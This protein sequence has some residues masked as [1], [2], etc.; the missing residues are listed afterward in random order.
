[1]KNTEHADL[2]LALAR[3]APNGARALA[4]EAGVDD[5]RFQRVLA[6]RLHMPQDV[7]EALAKQLAFDVRGFKNCVVMSSICRQIE[8]LERLETLGFKWSLV[9][10]IATTRELM[11]GSPLQRYFICKLGF[12]TTLRVLVVRM[13]SI[14]FKQ[15][16]DKYRL[17]DLP[18]VEIDG[19]DLGLLNDISIE[20]VSSAEKGHLTKVLKTAV[21]DGV[22]DGVMELVH[23]CMEEG[24]VTPSAKPMRRT[25][26]LPNSARIADTSSRLQE[27]DEPTRN[28]SAT[29][30]MYPI[31]AVFKGADAIGVRGD[32]TPVF[33]DI[34]TL[35]HGR[36]CRVSPHARQYCQQ[37]IV[38]EQ[39]GSDTDAKFRLLFDGP[40]ELVEKVCAPEHADDQ[41]EMA[42]ERQRRASKRLAGLDVSTE[43]LERANARLGTPRQR[44]KL[45]IKPRE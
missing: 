35:T 41:Q 37:L 42:E 33:I 32:E 28:M 3:L 23:R 21:E 26:R 31:S 34:K 19:G 18:V 9:C 43:Q 7:A 12:K 10:R 5:Q 13:A 45:S 4:V 14:K 27:W 11:G 2:L 30:H 44:E 17:Q 36:T 8:D 16:Y 6:G 20:F 29:H 15:F 22:I 1:M 40:M 39:T 38:F 25:R 24:A